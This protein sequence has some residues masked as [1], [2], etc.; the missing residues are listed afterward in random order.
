MAKLVRSF[1]MPKMT[2]SYWVRV[3]LVTGSSLLLFGVIVGPVRID[4]SSMEPTYT[5]GFSF[6]WR[7]RFWFDEP[8]AGDTPRAASRFSA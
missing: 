7:C 2:R 5:S 3:V 6:Y 4:G 1:F 8:A